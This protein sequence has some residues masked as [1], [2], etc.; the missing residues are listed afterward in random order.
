V[1]LGRRLDRSLLDARLRVGTGNDPPASLLL[2]LR[3]RNRLPV[4]CR[5][6]LLSLEMLSLKPLTLEM[7]RRNC[8]IL[9]RHLLRI[10]L[11]DAGKLRN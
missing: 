4:T 10:R 5:L 3:R 9:T 2:R 7:L 8:R 11:S 6:K 1:T